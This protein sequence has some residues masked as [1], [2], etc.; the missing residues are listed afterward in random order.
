MHVKCHWSGQ[1]HRHYWIETSSKDASQDQLRCNIH[2]NSLSTV[3]FVEISSRSRKYGVEIMVRGTVTP[4]NHHVEFMVDS[5]VSTQ[6]EETK[7]IADQPISF[8]S[9]EIV[10]RR[11]GDENIALEVYEIPAP[12]SP[13]DRMD[14]GNVEIRVSVI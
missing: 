12:N 2:Q 6:W 9:A 13:P 1:G 3:H 4:P 7:S 8:D 10:A 5:A 14:P 11:G